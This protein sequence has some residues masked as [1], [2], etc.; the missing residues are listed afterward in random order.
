MPAHAA[1]DAPQA[2]APA[3]A[4]TAKERELEW[5]LAEKEAEKERALAEKEAA[6][7]A[8]RARWAEEKAELERQLSSVRDASDSEAEAGGRA[9]AGA[10]TS[11]RRHRYSTFDPASEHEHGQEEQD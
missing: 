4:P 2:V 5:A 1:G 7:E 9:G 3:M 11:S 10:D 8:E 6:R